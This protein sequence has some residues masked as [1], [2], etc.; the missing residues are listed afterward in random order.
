MIG[1][2]DVVVCWV[3]VCLVGCSDCGGDVVV[4]GYWVYCD[5]SG[6]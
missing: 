2:V 4:F 1:F 6:L 5:G 3:V